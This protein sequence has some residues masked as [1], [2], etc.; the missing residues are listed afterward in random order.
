M[1]RIQKAVI[2]KNRKFLILLR[3]ASSKH[4]PLHW[5]F[6]G[7]KLEESEDPYKGME[8]EVVEETS[9]KVKALK[10]LAEYDMAIEGIPHRFT[11]YATKLLSGNVK[12]SKE[13][14][15]FKWANK[16]EVL[17]LKTEPYIKKYLKK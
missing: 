5:D 4:F 15:R 16:G 10:K 7:G 12:I 2:K 6:P 8:R 14:L 1:K 9:L 11:L 17:N 13:H 3:S